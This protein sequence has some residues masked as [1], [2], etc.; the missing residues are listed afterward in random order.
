[1]EGGAEAGRNGS[2]RDLLGGG[3]G[4]AA[5]AVRTQYFFSFFWVYTIDTDESMAKAIE[6]ESDDSVSSTFN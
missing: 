5:A 6:V 3:G 2:E 1:L 4:R